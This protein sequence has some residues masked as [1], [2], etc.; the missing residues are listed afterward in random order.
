[1][2]RLILTLGG[3]LTSVGCSLPPCLLLLRAVLSKSEISVIGK[4]L[5]PSCTEIVAF[6][7]SL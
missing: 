5:L 2:V 4:F 6:E 3:S 1:M 7:S